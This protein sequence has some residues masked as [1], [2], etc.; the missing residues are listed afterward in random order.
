M[1]ATAIL[2]NILVEATAVGQF[3]VHSEFTGKMLPS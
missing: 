2:A 3:K 1:T